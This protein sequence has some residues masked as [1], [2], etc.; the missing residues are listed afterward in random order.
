MG[1][2]IFGKIF[3]HLKPALKYIGKQGWDAFKSMSSDVINGESLGDAGKNTLFKTAQNV[4]SDA[5]NKLASFKRAKQS[6]GGRK[7][8]KRSVK[9]AGKRKVYKKRKAKKKKVYKKRTHKKVNK[10]NKYFK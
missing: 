2:G 4:L 10:I 7:R 5:N 3:K 9:K 8:R 1:N 6:G